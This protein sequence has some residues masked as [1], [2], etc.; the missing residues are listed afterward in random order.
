MAGD[1]T[2]NVGVLPVFT[3]YPALGSGYALILK[4]L[5]S[6]RMVHAY[7]ITGAKGLGKATYARYLAAAMRC[8][9]QDKPCGHC[10]SCER[11]YS[12]T[13][14]DVVE[15]VSQDQKQIPIE[16]IRDTIEVISQH[17]YGGGTRIVIVEPVEKLTPAAQNCLLKSLEE[18]QAKVVFLLLAHESSALLSTI[19]SRCAAVKLS[20]WPD[21]AIETVLHA[22]HYT[23]EQIG[24]VLPRASGNIGMA[25]A[26][27]QNEA[28]E[29]ELQALID[30]A[31]AADHD[32]DV[33]T[34][35]TKLKDDRDGAQRALN[36][37]EQALHQA[38]LVKTGL[39]SKTAVTSKSILEWATHATIEDLS[40]TMQAVFDTRRKRQSQVNWQASIDRLL[41]KILEAKTTWQQ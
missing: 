20:P 38:L 33:V 19:A 15:V 28:S 3:D 21:A 10:E 36:A 26:M 13:D 11:I 8:S 25:L 31:L 16:R 30:Q 37:L 27:L 41:M 40:G 18:P 34:L 14:P 23:T 17:S 2:S 9:G 4:Q 5:N 35:S 39:L 7:L 12:A 32:A 24:A 29:T 22:Q 6:G 1:R